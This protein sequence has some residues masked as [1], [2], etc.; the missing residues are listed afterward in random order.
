[1]EEDWYGEEERQIAVCCR[2]VMGHVVSLT[3]RE[4]TGSLG[5]VQS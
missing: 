2:R 3:L 1:M 5:E 4:P